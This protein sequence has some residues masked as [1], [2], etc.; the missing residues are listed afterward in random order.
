MTM[1]ANTKQ[2]NN[3]YLKCH[4]FTRYVRNSPLNSINFWNTES[5]FG[6]HS[7]QDL[8]ESSGFWIQKDSFQAILIFTSWI[9][10]ILT[11][12]KWINRNQSTASQMC[13]FGLLFIFLLH[14]LTKVMFAHFCE[15]RKIWMNSTQLSI[16]VKL[17]LCFVAYHFVWILQAWLPMTNYPPPIISVPGT[18]GKEDYRNRI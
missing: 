17:T 8:Q 10:S 2:S 5:R 1:L 6:I 14:W 12:L 11:P 9:P 18:V 16:L 13:L 4:M 7:I 3:S 15:A